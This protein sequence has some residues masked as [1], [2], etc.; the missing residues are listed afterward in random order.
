MSLSRREF[1][2]N[3]A[4]LTAGAAALPEQILAFEKLYTVNAVPDVTGLVAITDI[5][6]IGTAS[7]SKPLLMNFHNESV[8]EL[9]LG[10]NCFGGIMRWLAV[11][12]D[13]IRLTTPKKFRYEIISLGDEISDYFSYLN[14]GMRIIDQDM[15]QHFLSF[16]GIHKTGTLEDLIKKNGLTSLTL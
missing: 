2:R 15:K 4:V 14:G 13:P 5:T 12:S 8:Q 3:L 9:V 10:L 1:I 7:V 11:P 16:K 6:L